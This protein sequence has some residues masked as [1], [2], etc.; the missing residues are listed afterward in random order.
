[1]SNRRQVWET[2]ARLLARLEEGPKSGESPQAMSAEIEALAQQVRKLGKEQFKANTLSEKQILELQQALDEL[3]TTKHQSD[4][5]IEA[6][7]EERAALIQKQYLES[8]LPVLDSVENAIAS[9]DKYLAIRD[10]A[11]QSD[12]LDE[13]RGVL[14]SPADRVMLAGW[15]DGLRIVRERLLE[16]LEA[17][18]VTPIP[19]IGHPFDPHLHVVVERTSEAA[20]G[21]EPNTIVGEERRGY[22]NDAGVLRYAD[23]IVY[24]P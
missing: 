6:L 9:G 21:I 10:K 15:L 11:A 17:G 7:L 19:A 18:E 3:Q 2:L 12:H 23:V 1:M 22:R 24:R 20:E 8:L 13:R 5:T 16:I 14:V 4:K